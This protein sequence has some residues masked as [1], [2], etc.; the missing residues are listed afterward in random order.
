[1]ATKTPPTTTYT[2]SQ[3]ALNVVRQLLNAKGWA[4]TLG[5][6]YDGG[7]LVSKYLPELDLSWL[8]TDD[9][10]RAL[11]A[12]ELKTYQAQDKA[13]GEKQVEVNLTDKQA[14]LVRKA[15]LH[16]IDELI[17]AKGLGPNPVFA[18]IVDAFSI[19]LDPKG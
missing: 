11:K 9:E 3:Q 10:V 14:A 16:F 13:W 2:I 1:M 7:K 15:F 4:E 12:A 19:P 17:K 18:E 6:A 5:E 8:K